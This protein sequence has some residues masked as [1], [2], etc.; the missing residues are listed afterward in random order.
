MKAF[1]LNF[2]DDLAMTLCYPNP[3]RISS[4]K[5]RK[6]DAD[7]SGRAISGYKIK[8]SSDGMN[9]V[10][11]GSTVN[12]PPRVAY[13][14]NLSSSQH[15]DFTKSCRNQ[16]VSARCMGAIALFLAAALGVGEA[17]AQTAVCSN[18]PG[19][20]ERI[21][22]TEDAN[23]T[24]DIDIN[25]QDG[26]DI[27][28]S[29]ESDHGIHAFHEGIGKIT[30]RIQGVTDN[31][32][33]TTSGKLSSGVFGR[34]E[35][36]GGVDITV[37]DV[38]ITTTGEGT[39]TRNA[40]GVSGELIISGDH[41][42]YDG[43]YNVKINVSGSRI[44]TMGSAGYGINGK[45][46]SVPNEVILMGNLEITASNTE[47]IT[48]GKIGRGIDARTSNTVGDLIITMTGGSITTAGPRAVGILADHGKKGSTGQSGDVIIHTTDANITTM[49]DGSE[50]ASLTDAKGIWAIN[51]TDGEGHITIT[52]I[53]TNVH[54]MGPTGQAVFG[55]RVGGDGNVNINIQGGEITTNN[56]SATAIDGRHDNQGSIV[57]VLRDVIVKS[58]GEQLEPG[59]PGTYS[60]GIFAWQKGG[61]DIIIDAHA[62][63]AI[64]TKGVFSRGIRARLKGTGNI[65]VTAHKGSSVTTMG[66]NSDGIE[67]FGPLIAN[68]TDETRSMM[69]IVDGDVTA[70]GEDSRG[71]K[72]GYVLSN[73]NA[74]RIAGLDEEGYRRNLVTVNGRVYG[75]SGDGAGI[76]L[77]G[78]GK[79]LIGPNGVVGA[80][81]GV[82]ILATGDRLPAVDGDP[83][84]KPKLYIG[85]DL[86]DRRMQEVIGD[87]W[88]LNDGGETTIVVNDVTLHEGA[89]GVTGFIAPN[90]AWNVTTKAQ[91]VKV[92][93]RSDPANWV[94]TEPA[95]DVT[96]D[97]DFSAEDFIE[98]YAPRA[99][100]Y[101][102][103]PEVLLG[104]TGA[105]GPTGRFVLPPD[106]PSWVRLS[107]G[108]RAYEPDRSTV[109]AKHDF[110][111]IEVEAGR[112]VPFGEEARGWISV[113]HVRG[114]ADVSSPTGG[115][116][117]DVEGIGISLG[118]H[119]Q[120][121]NDYYA[122]GSFSLTDYSIDF[123][124]DTLGRL[125]S[126]VDGD[127]RSMAVEAG[128]HIA[129]RD[130][131][132]FMPRAW[133]TRS[134]GS[135]DRFTDVVDA[136]VSFPDP[137][138]LVGGFGVTAKTADTGDSGGL[139]L[140]GSL[141]IE[142]IFSGAQTDV[143]VSGEKLS[144]RPAKD[145]V[146]VALGG[147]YRRGPFLFGAQ[148]SAR[149]GLG[150]EGR[151]YSGSLNLGIRF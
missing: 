7:F 84:I 67:V 22:C 35:G 28:T 73:G 90:G 31:N 10:P 142:R 97:R 140:H 32:T 139:S 115:G 88:I 126:G 59:Y 106:S 20:G 25:L 8:S 100:L 125:K 103:L 52:L 92:T 71:V 41:T 112:N 118:V 66:K 151:E 2:E 127:G 24:N 121:A 9:G 148:V 122:T 36:K 34:H 48:K 5:R 12:P 144:Q 124:S 114:S 13:A 29:G 81:S 1:K 39:A 86:N 94:I 56:Y 113:R 57:I 79:V 95:D 4:V 19:T 119:W 143:H 74:E 61:G 138:H 64:S 27:N 82:A 16:G 26:L 68:A 63:T 49:W 132:Q 93:N 141:D 38:E 85:M 96:A 50:V 75:G 37:T 135:A 46:E 77:A 108:R 120:S 83:T 62:G 101:E 110:D 76:Y 136:R 102:S 116:E 117:I 89:T 134:K 98:E 11:A 44:S 42:P 33:I 129:F 65:K 58:N 60:S 54:T 130:T 91:G 105:A 23:S 14:Q 99:A 150:S 145:S 70:S 123:S 137:D 104:L 78:G 133:L 40:M 72:F 15:T 69:V 111:R 30:I 109:G 147:T 107:G 53:D 17:Q 6:V 45:F 55:D 146:L 43:N 87:D 80:D 131:M 18:T 21:E 149:E 51:R 3:I 128:R 47:I